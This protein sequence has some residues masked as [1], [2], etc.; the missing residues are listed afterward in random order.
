MVVSSVNPSERSSFRDDPMHM[1]SAK[2]APMAAGA[3]EAGVA[4]SSLQT[5][6]PQTI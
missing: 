4:T 6:Q 1:A 5:S 3:V 2:A